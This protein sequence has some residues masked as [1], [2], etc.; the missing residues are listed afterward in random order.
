M[1]MDL[2]IQHR[3]RLNTEAYSLLYGIRPSEERPE[4]QH[5]S[6]DLLRDLVKRGA[7]LDVNQK[8]HVRQC[9]DCRDFVELFLAEARQAGKSVPDLVHDS[10]KAHAARPRH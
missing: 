1:E 4:Q 10:A 8:Q 2:L 3:M 6:L 5:F 9:R 7:S